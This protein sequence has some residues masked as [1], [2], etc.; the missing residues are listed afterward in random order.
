MFPEKNS[1]LSV[2]YHPRIDSSPQILWPYKTG[3]AGLE[4]ATCGFGDR[5]STNWSY[6]PLSRVLRKN[7]FFFPKKDTLAATRTVFLPLDLVRI[8]FLVLPRPIGRLMI[9]RRHEGNDL[10]HRDKTFSFVLK[11]PWKKH[12]FKIIISACKTSYGENKRL[13][14]SRASPK[15]LDLGRTRCYAMISLTTPAPTVLPP[16]RMANRSSFS[17]ATG[18]ISSASIATL[19]P[20]ITI[21]RK[22]VV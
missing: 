21:D 13:T 4:P 1:Q 20:G 15:M 14:A 12:G 16:S 11:K 9:T 22:S 6:R 3:Q 10:L 18:M 7:L 19:S 8:L 17:I 2:P 5:R